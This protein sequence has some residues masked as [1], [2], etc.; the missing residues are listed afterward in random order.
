MAPIPAAISMGEGPDRDSSQPGRLVQRIP[1]C[2]R[3][4]GL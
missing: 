1:V 2:K 3:Q 4:P